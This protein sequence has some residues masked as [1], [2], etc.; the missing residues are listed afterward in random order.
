MCLNANTAE[1]T[2]GSMGI[3]THRSICDTTAVAKLTFV[4]VALSGI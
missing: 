2:I 1:Q 4:I 3:N